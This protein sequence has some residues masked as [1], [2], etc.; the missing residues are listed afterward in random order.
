MMHNFFNGFLCKDLEERC[1]KAEDENGML[2]EELA[3]VHAT[4]ARERAFAHEVV[5]GIHLHFSVRVYS[6]S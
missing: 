3:A 1:R 2:R 6:E 4:A 5:R